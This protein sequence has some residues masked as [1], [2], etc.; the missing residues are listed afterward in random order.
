MRRFICKDIEEG[1]A[2]LARLI[3]LQAG[4]WRLQRGNVED[5]DKEPSDAEDSGEEGEDGADD[6]QG[7]GP[8]CRRGAAAPSAKKSK[9]AAAAA[10][11]PA[12]APA[13]GKRGRKAKQ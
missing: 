3:D 10:P 1:K 9:A 7:G 4:K 8:S 5:V 2:Y 13:A 12:P 6:E 11:A